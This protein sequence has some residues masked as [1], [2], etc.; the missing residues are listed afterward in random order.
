MKVEIN[1]NGYNGNKIFHI[2]PS[3]STKHPSI[4]FCNKVIFVQRVNN[5]CLKA[6]G[7]NRLENIWGNSTLMELWINIPPVTKARVS[8]FPNIILI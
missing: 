4:G 3:I 5:I 2:F 1:T 7:K 6:L 8:C